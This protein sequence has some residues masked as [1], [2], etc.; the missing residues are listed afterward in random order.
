MSSIIIF[1]KGKSVL[2]C[3]K[4]YANGFDK[5]AFINMLRIT[6]YERY[7]SDRCNYWFFRTYEELGYATRDKT[8]SWKKT[9]NFADYKY[10]IENQLGIEKVF[11]TG[12]HSHQRIYK[13]LDK[14]IEYDTHWR[15]SMMKELLWAQHSRSPDRKWFPPSGLLALDYFIH[16]KLFKK[17][18]LV[19]FDFYQVET[20]LDNKDI[21]NHYY[22]LDKDSKDESLINKTG[23]DPN[24]VQYDNSEFNPHNPKKQI[25]YIITQVKQNPDI[26]FE[27][28]TNCSIIQQ[29]KFN[30]LKVL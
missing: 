23:E 3:T 10:Y 13:Y 17:I 30:N 16:T 2:R 29:Q 27:I 6:G 7:I 19:G 15:R 12:N 28:Y 21:Y 1:G 8:I 5:V 9:E 24:K 22:F 14:N 26:E 11:N 20:G 4:E 25:D 18:A